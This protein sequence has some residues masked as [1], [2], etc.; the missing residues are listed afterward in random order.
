VKANSINRAA[1]VLTTTIVLLSTIALFST[2]NRLVQASAID[3]PSSA[4]LGDNL[5]V[6][7]WWQA[8]SRD[9]DNNK[10]DDV[11]DRIIENVE[12]VQKNSASY[13]ISGRHPNIRASLLVDFGRA[14]DESD[15]AALSNIVGTS[16][17]LKFQYVD[18][19]SIRGVRPSI[20]ENLSK[21]GGV[22]MV[23]LQQR[24]RAALDV[25]ARAVKARSSTEYSDV[26]EDFGVNGAG[27]NIAI[28][29]TGVDDE[30]ESLNGKYVAGVDTTGPTDL[31]FNP[32]DASDHDIFHGTHVAGIAMGDGGAG[33]DYM[34]IAPG[35][36]LIDVRVLNEKGE[37]TSESV[38]RGIEWCIANKDR[39]NIR[40]LNLSLGTDSNSN[41]SDAQSQA[42]NAAAE[43]GLVVVAAVG[44]DGEDGY[45]SSPGA[46]DGAISVGAL[47]DHNTINRGNDTV[48]SYSNC[49]PRLDDDD[50][51]PYDELKPDVTGPGTYIWSAKGSNGV[52]S[53]G[54]Q[55]LSGTSMATPHVAG[56]V[57]LMLQANPNLT[58]EEIKEVLHDT[59]EA[60]G[61]PYSPSLS[62]KYSTSYGW[63][64]VDAY[65]A[66][67][68][69]TE[70]FGP[71]DFSVSSE[72]ISF[73]DNTPVEDQKILVSAT[74]HNEG[75]YEGTCDVAFY[76]EAGLSTSLGKV[77]G[78]RIAGGGSEDVG[79][80]VNCTL[81]GD[82]TLTVVVENSSPSEE[83]TSNNRA[84]RGVTVG[85]PPV[86][87]D[88][89]LI[90]Y[91]IRFPTLAFSPALSPIGLSR[92]GKNDSGPIQQAMAL[93]PVM[94]SIRVD[95]H[96]V[97]QTSATCDVKIYYDEKTSEKLIENFSDIFVE[98]LSDNYVQTSWFIPENIYGDHTV[99]AVIESVVPSDNDPKNNEASRDVSLPSKMVTGDVAISDDD[100][101][102]SDNN[103]PA[104]SEIDI[105]ATVYNTGVIDVENVMVVL[106][107]DNMPVGLDTIPYIRQGFENS[108]SIP[109]K[110]D[111]GEH[112]IKVKVS[113][114]GVEESNYANNTA[115]KS[116]SVREVSLFFLWLALAI[117]VGLG[118]GFAFAKIRKR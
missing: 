24:V 115:I 16:N 99:Y 94:R 106:Y 27:I 100:I 114:E 87:P 53:N 25:S 88:L 3:H 41:G 23:E 7:H 8:W 75:D 113:L 118:S 67:R 102:F 55:Q 15:I 103:P 17:V 36:G 33:G 43:A 63:G 51:D 91:D 37:G 5:Q 110:A 117:A 6:V 22:V 56:V 79:I 44:N 57:A 86:E 105:N 93:R 66:V 72:D 89:T 78:V 82:H 64:M 111:S 50:Y 98:S 2:T 95:V 49:G 65:A 58:P 40:V 9:N 77:S 60:R 61:V 112:V 92:S 35:A 46:A 74:I 108:A 104:G 38:I 54:Y 69:V 20:V 96:N 47:F 1:S 70:N 52:A 73:S 32:D 30:H 71:P 101:T 48:A 21:L 10:I 29:D 80:G 83:D 84:S 11:I 4:S 116:I 68:S 34:G 13:I 107:V 97:G 90:E 76:R 42:V 19:V 62:H 45:I 12:L 85:P 18:A 81:Q 39:Y 14:V 31:E 26:W 59:S 109:W 28:L